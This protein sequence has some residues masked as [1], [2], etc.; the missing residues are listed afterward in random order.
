[1]SII[2][3]TQEFLWKIIDSPIILFILTIECEENV[4]KKSE[5]CLKLDATFILEIKK[6]I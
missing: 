1:M 3:W 6:K 5:T 4:F 2:M